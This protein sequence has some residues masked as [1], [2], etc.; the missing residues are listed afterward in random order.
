M[1]L[2]PNGNGDGNGGIVLGG[3]VGGRSHSY[4]NGGGSSG[5]GYKGGRGTCYSNNVGGDGDEL[6]SEAVFLPNHRDGGSGGGG[7]AA[8]EGL[9]A[10]Q[11]DFLMD[12][13]GNGP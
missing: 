12:R 10:G 9:S 1:S 5:G 6:F 2:L 8:F 3:K 11:L 13:V 4:S 7:G